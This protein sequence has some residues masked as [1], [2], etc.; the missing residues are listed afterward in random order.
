MDEMRKPEP[1]KG[2]TFIDAVESGQ[3]LKPLDVRSAVEWLKESLIIYRLTGY[4]IKLS[5]VN[6]LID[7]AFEDVMKDE[8]K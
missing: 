2:K 3:R 6:L 7:E 4:V 1:L 8:T 5:D